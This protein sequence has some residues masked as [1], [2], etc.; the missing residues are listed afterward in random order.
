LALS[1]VTLSDASDSDAFVYLREAAN[2]Y[3]FG[4]PQAAAAL[5]RAAVESRLKEVAA[6]QFGRR[7]VD[8]ADLNDLIDDLAFRRGRLITRQQRDDADFVRRTGN[9]ILHQQATDDATALEVFEAA[10]RVI[11]ALRSR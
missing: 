9:K 5:A 3:I 4:L 10:R 8:N 6:Q 7:A 11:Q 1:G 2:C